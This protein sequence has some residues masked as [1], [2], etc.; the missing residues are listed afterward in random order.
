[1]KTH[2][3]LLFCL[4]ALLA[5]CSRDGKIINIYA[6]GVRG[7][8]ISTS[9]SGYEG[10]YWKNLSLNVIPNPTPPDKKF[11]AVDMTMEGTDM[12]IL[13]SLNLF[14]D[15]AQKTVYWKNGVINYL[16]RGASHSEATDIF[17]Q[18]ANTY[19]LV[20]DNKD[21]LKNMGYY[22]NGTYHAI[23]ST[24]G[25][26]KY[27]KQIFVH[28]DTVRIAGFHYIGDYEDKQP[29][30]WTDDVEVTLSAPVTIIDGEAT[31]V[32]VTEDGTVF[33]SGAVT[34]DAP[35]LLSKAVYWRNGVYNELTLSS[36]Y[37]AGFA[38]TVVVE[39]GDVYV[40]GVQYDG[41]YNAYLTYWK[42][43]V[44]VIIDSGVTGFS[45]VTKIAVLD[46]KVYC[47]GFRD[48]RYSA[49][50]WINGSRVD[51]GTRGYQTY[52]Y[53]LYVGYQE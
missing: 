44:P 47:I 25:I 51:L 23:A 32:F 7:D 31:S 45:S 16:D 46:G 30:L 36:G 12:Y 1:M 26:G 48:I 9:L 52:V 40:G 37:I 20:N 49:A 50:L 24:Q 2:S 4:A 27:G 42:N 19:V 15:D 6:C 17:V 22:E 5:S 3:F 29:R 28:N 39:D 33:V 41:S 13:G 21:N 8:T 35:V 14:T 34:P 38:N 43:G 10:I 11:G 18:H 53:G